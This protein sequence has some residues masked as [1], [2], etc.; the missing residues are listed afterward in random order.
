M[1]IILKLYLR[2]LE[3]KI[4]KEYDPQLSRKIDC[5]IYVLEN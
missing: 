2:Y 4:D 3:S 5:L 1:K